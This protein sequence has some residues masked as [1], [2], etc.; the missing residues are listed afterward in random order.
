M[1]AFSTSRRS[2]SIC[3][4]YWRKSTPC[5]TVTCVRNVCFQRK[6]SFACKVWFRF[7]HLFKSFFDDVIFKI[8][9][10]VTW[11]TTGLIRNGHRCLSLMDVDWRELGYL[12]I[13]QRKISVFQT[14][15]CSVTSSDRM[16]H[17]VSVK[18]PTVHGQSGG[19]RGRGWVPQSQWHMHCCIRLPP[20][21]ASHDL[22]HKREQ[23][24]LLDNSSR[25]H[26]F[27]AKFLSCIANVS[28]TGRGRWQVSALSL[29]YHPLRRVWS[30][31]M[32]G[33]VRQDSDYFH[34]LPAE[35][36][37]V[38]RCQLRLDKIHLQC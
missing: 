27:Q 20:L 21:S 34:P 15:I 36:G 31:L 2:A 8:C 16:G 17:T 3:L 19:R 6:F 10:N 28:T 30:L 26:T 14:E 32:S 13:F 35:R 4:L 7:P 11:K 37:K 24:P 1:E 5:K 25:C 22:K 9:L 29:T 38:P 33:L 18:P 23:L 12:D